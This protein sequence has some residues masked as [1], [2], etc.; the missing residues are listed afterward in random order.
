MFSVLAR[1]KLT[2]FYPGF[3]SFGCF[4]IS[5][6]DNH[7]GIRRTLELPGMRLSARIIISTV[8]ASGDTWIC[9]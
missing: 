5:S 1:L 8:I 4:L 7:V 6:Y 3:N 9:M 2:S